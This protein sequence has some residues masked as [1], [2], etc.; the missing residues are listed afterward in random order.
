MGFVL[1]PEWQPRG[2]QEEAIEKLVEGIQSG[3]ERLTLLGVTGSGKTFTMAGVIARVNRPALILSPNKTLA[4]QLY[5]E[6]KTFFPENAVEY[7]VSYYDYYQPE[8]YIPQTDTYIDKDAM[9]NDRIDRL[10]LS[11]TSALL[12]RRDVVCVASI[13]CIYGLGSPEEYAAMTVSLRRG[14]T[15]DRRE[16][17]RKLVEMQYTRS[18]DLARGT[19]RLRGEVLDIHSAYREDAYRI[20]FFGDEI[21][22]LHSISPLTGTVTADLERLVLYPA[23]HFVQSAQTLN[24]ALESIEEELEERLKV[25]RGEG[26]L[27]EAERLEQRTRYDL[28]MIHELGYCSGIENYSRHFTGRAPGEPPYTLL[29]YFPE[30]LLVFIDE[31]HVA[32]GQLHGMYNADRSRKETLVN[33]GFRLPSALDNRPLKAE[34]FFS[35]VP[36]IVFVSATPGEFE[37]KISAR[38]VE[39]LIRP[40]GLVD[41]AVEVRPATGQVADLVRELRA[42]AERNERAL[43][44]TLTK[45]TAEELSR[46][47]EDEGL[48]VAHLHSEIH[49][50]ERIERL[51]ALRAGEIDVLVGINLLREGLDLPEVSLVA[52]LDADREGFLRSET[53][54]VQMMGRAARHRTGRVILYA[55][56]VTG[57][58]RRAIKETRRRREKQLAYNEAHGITPQSI[59]KPLESLEVFAPDPFEREVLEEIDAEE[60]P[61]ELRERVLEEMEREME[62]AADALD[63]ERA[64]YLRDRIEAMGGG[65]RKNG[66]KGPKR[67]GGRRGKKGGIRRGQR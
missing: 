8:A 27:L 6:F 48:K 53:S 19:M 46:Y 14:E 15:V 61:P 56:S 25:L 4:A 49:T 51:K 28:E 54:L 55:D 41:P 32:V 65:T 43:V 22:S 11:A 64:A 13:S 58:M 21:E 31:S 9:I 57:S 26:K 2:D 66:W 44:T 62:A 10:R 30:D 24:R 29:D 18:E 3:E 35:K 33:F 39:Q 12:E 36:C 47:L 63:F 60:I 16:L 45:R 20:V 1:A 59:V 42:T 34:E 52:I 38:I 7:F 37:R 5:A 17:L 40:T 50:L 67:R 23:R